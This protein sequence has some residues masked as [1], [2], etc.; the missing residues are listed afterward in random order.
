MDALH[1]LVQQSK[2][3]YLGISDT[4]AWV[5]AAANTYAR[6]H[7]KTPFSVYQG[8]WNIMRR[9]FERDIIPMAQHFGMA[10]C[11]WDALGGGRLQTKK[12]LEARKQAG[13]GLR[14]IH[15]PE[16]TE[17]E[18]KISEALEK[19]AAEH[20]T[21]SIQQIA[22]AYISQKTR[23]V[24]PLVGV[25]KVEQLQ[26]NIK[27][28]SIHLTDEQIQYLEGVKEFDPGFPATMIG[29]DPKETGVSGPMVASFAHI[30]WQKA[31]RPIGR[32]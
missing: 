30:A 5:V 27:S 3:L 15:G 8:R 20:G 13:E 16:Q 21:E 12:Q 6:A 24:I 32:G 1:V 29:E 18:R 4:P 23:N 31:S 22:L 25:R 19:V 2:V 11:A 9:D 26:D 7:G 17:D 14:A 10:L 28:L